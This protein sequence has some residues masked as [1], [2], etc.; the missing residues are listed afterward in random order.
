MLN[1]KDKKAIRACLTVLSD[2]F[3][4]HK[5][6]Y[7]KLFFQEKDITVPDIDFSA[8]L[9]VGL[10]K[11]VENKFRANV[12]IFPLSGKFIVSDFLISIHNI[13]DGRY[14]RNRDDVWPIYAYESAYIAKKAIIREGDYVLDLATGSGIIALFCADKAKKVI[15]TDINPKAINYAKFNA[16]LNGLDTKVEFRLGD[17]FEPVKNEK[18]D[19]IIW[20][21]PTLATPNLPNKY[22]IYCFGGADGLDFTRRF[23]NEAPDHLRPNGRLQWLDPSLGDSTNPESLEIVNAVWRNKSFKVVYEQRVKPD[24]LFSL[25]KAVDEA[26]FNPSK[27]LARPL[28]IKP[29][30]SKEYSNWLAYLRQNNFTHLHAGMYMVYPSDIFRVINTRPDKIIFP[31]MNYLPQDWHFLGTTRIRQLLRIC[32]GYSSE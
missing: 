29:L 25:Y 5:E 16:I 12:F 27:G 1:L 31:R 23:I 13:Q 2:F 10:V 15:G 19:L 22:P 11:R 18:F 24:P 7:I 8:L 3:K 30:T 26:L 14:L 28:W 4:K 20:N 6:E 21:G 9:K 17:L 32:E